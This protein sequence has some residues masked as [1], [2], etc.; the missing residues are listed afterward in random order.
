[1]WQGIAEAFQE[2]SSNP[3]IRCIVMSGAG[4]KAFASGA[5][6]SQFKERRSDANAAAEYAKISMAG[7]KMLE[8]DKPFIAQIRGFCMGGISIALAADIRIARSLYSVYCRATIYRHEIGKPSGFSWTIKGKGDIDYGKTVF[9]ARGRKDGLS[10]IR[11]P[12]DKLE[13]K[14]DITDRISQNAP[15]RRHLNLP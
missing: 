4:D 14:A 5:D 2:F 11:A 9:C 7:R 6:I 12:I 15:S 13:E 8:C 10:G 1:M 3:K